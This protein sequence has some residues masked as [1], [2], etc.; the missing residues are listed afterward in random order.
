MVLQ[1]VTCIDV[2]G[3]RQR[4]VLI[5]ADRVTRIAESIP[6]TLR[7]DSRGK[8]LLPALIDTNVRLRDAQLTGAAMT[9]TARE[10][11][12]G[13]IG[14]IVLAPDSVPAVDNAIV[15]EFV[16]NYRAVSEGARLETTISATIDEDTLSNI[17]IL[18]KNGAI[19]PY[20]TTAIS[21]HLMV[22][23]AEY[24][25]MHQSTL[26]CKAHDRKLSA[27]G[28]MV[29]GPVAT[30]LG[31]TGIPPLGETVHVARMIEIAREF[32]IPILFKS[33]AS[34]RSVEMIK[35]ARREGIRVECEV[36]L[37]HL[38]H[39]DEACDGFNTTAKL[40]PPLPRRDDMNRLR[41]ALREG[42]IDQLTVAHQ[43][44]SPVNKEVAFADAAYGCESIQEALPL[45]FS[46][47]IEPGLISWAD[48]VRMCI[49]NPGRSI[50]VKEAGIIETSRRL[51]LFDPSEPTVVKNSQSLYNGETLEGTVTVLESDLL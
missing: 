11:L 37:H 39:N 44:N 21:N 1:N 35:A 14:T 41:N 4:D 30:R 7:S 34:P 32:G 3:A 29:A 13:G 46:K 18:S 19:A 15:L 24:V 40:D 36:S 33:I 48:L 5:E 42:H 26:F 17:A 20:V 12:Q 6:G 27:D 8:I 9:K 43:P 28:H 49:V 31:L 47:L 22:P 10:A 38:L 50:G 16:R 51:V 2:N 25:K 23:I 45:Y